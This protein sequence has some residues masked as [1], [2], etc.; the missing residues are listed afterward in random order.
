MWALLCLGFHVRLDGAPVGCF[1]QLAPDAPATGH[2]RR[3]LGTCEWGWQANWL[4]AF[5]CT[6][7]S[8]CRQASCCPPCTPLPVPVPCPA[9]PALH[10]FGS[11]C[12]HKICRSM[13]AREVLPS[14]HT[15]AYV[16]E[17]VPPLNGLRS[18]N[19]TLQVHGGKRDAA[20]PAHHRPSGGRGGRRRTAADPQRRHLMW[21]HAAAPAGID[22]SCCEESWLDEQRGWRAQR[23][24]SHCQP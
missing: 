22:L 9:L 13:E 14:L 6:C 11:A 2:E 15:A 16:A 20:L 17:N 21:A 3:S 10:Q 24:A 18:A 4:P 5:R 19:L 23:R 8:S 12:R 1:M 7:E